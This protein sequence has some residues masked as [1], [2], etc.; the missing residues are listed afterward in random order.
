M[1]KRLIQLTPKFK[2]VDMMCNGYSI[3]KVM[4]NLNV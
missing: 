3:R 1:K 2:I 4:D